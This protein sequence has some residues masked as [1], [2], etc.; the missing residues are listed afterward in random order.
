MTAAAT[1]ASPDARHSTAPGALR[2]MA[3]GAFWFSVMTTFVKLAGRTLPSSEIV[4]T[5]AVLTLG[6]GLWAVRA[7]PRPFGTERR[8]LVQRGLLGALALNCFFWSVTHLPLA[9]ASVIQYT[10][11]IF[12]TVLAALVLGERVTAR[13]VA[14]IA[15]AVLGTVFVANPPWLGGATHAALPWRGVAIALV[16]AFCS[17]AAYVTIR[18]IGR[19]EDPATIVLY[20]PL[21]TIPAM[22]PFVGDDAWRWPTPIEWALL[23]G[24]SVATQLAQVAMTRGLQGASAAR[25]TA[26]G[27]LQVAFAAGWGGVVFGQWPTG[28]TLLGAALV[29]GSA[30]LAARAPQGARPT[31]AA[32]PAAQPDAAMQAV[33]AAE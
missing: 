11:P 24:L 33:T 14:A 4:M 25:A 10:N 26:V 28:W 8:L 21:C 22:V 15:G 16:G 2:S 18:R 23:V 17:A 19:R 9:E 5:R 12:A 7:V 3:V 6:L 30:W 32:P 20:L 29:V 31:R 27:N 1:S 13:G